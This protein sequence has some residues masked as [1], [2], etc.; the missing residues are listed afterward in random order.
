MD[1]QRILVAYE[2]IARLTGQMLAAAEASQWDRLTT[3]EEECSTL[4]DPLLVEP[5]RAAPAT[6]EYRQRKAELIRSILA[7]DA[8]IRALVEPRLEDLSAL[9]GATRQKQKLN[10]AYLADG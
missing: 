3:L 7:D 10:R 8:R 4:F 6:L 5:E 2:R 1:E 9:L